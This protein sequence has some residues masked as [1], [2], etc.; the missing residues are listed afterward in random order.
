MRT[1]CDKGWSEVDHASVYPYY[2]DDSVFKE[3]TELLNRLS[4][5]ADEMGDFFDR[6]KV[7]EEEYLKTHPSGG[8]KDGE[9]APKKKGNTKERS[10]IEQNGVSTAADCLRSVLVE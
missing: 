7:L 1:L 3:Y 8:D 4:G 5:L 2:K 6:L 9:K 10:L